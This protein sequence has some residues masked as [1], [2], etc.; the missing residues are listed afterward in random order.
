MRTLSI[1][2]SVSV[3]AFV[4]VLFGCGSGSS[5]Y[6]A[7]R[8]Q[9]LS[10][11]APA[12]GARVTLVPL[13]GKDDPA[14]RPSGVVGADGS[15][16]LWTYD[17]VSRE[18]REGAPPGKYAVVVTWFSQTGLDDVDSNSPNA[19]RLGGR[20]RDAAKSPFR[21]EIKDEPTDLDPIKVSVSGPRANTKSPFGG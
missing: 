18:S 11:E 1:A 7:T 14:V 6:S 4:P 8:G 17:P 21:V 19:D 5:G 15:F 9:V 10:G 12:V 3:V 16:S 20:Y 13:S 2:V